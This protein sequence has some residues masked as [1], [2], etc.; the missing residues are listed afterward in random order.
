VKQPKN[1]KNSLMKKLFSTSLLALSLGILSTTAGFA[2]T[3]KKFGAIDTGKVLNDFW[4]MDILN[5]ELK[6]EEQRIQKE[7]DEKLAEIKV[8][9]DEILKLREQLNDQSLPKAKR[10]E[11]KDTFQLRFNRLNEADRVRREYIQAKLKALNVRRAEKQKE[12]ID[13]VKNVVSKYATE[14]GYDAISEKAT[15]YFVK[16]EFDLTAKII[17]ILNEG[18]EKKE[19][20]TK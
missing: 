2:Q 8:L 12:M 6:D 7:N 4:R 20:T 10:D 3:L 11:L 1:I 9:N 14:N 19:E 5:K 16:T 15:F 17:T 18:H 13:D